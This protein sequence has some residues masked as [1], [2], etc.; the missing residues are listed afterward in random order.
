MII[1]CNSLTPRRLPA[2]LPTENPL[3]SMVS[4]DFYRNREPGTLFPGARAHV[5]KN[6]SGKVF[7][8]A[9][10][11]YL[12][13]LVPIFIYIYLYIG[14]S[15]CFSLVYK[16]SEAGSQAGSQRG[17]RDLQELVGGNQ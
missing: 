16:K 5:K 11:S 1:Y 3:K 4:N 13:P 14:I 2:I 6:G 7:I 9:R 8:C 10:A 12:R 15:C 17:V